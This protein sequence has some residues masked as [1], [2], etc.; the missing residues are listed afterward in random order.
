[1]KKQKEAATKARMTRIRDEQKEKLD[2]ASSSCREYLLCNVV[3]ILSD[4]L[5]DICKRQPQDPVD[6]MA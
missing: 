2:Q 5:L 4:G 6:S 3:P 1:L